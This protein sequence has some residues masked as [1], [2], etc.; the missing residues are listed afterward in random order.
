MPIVSKTL[1]IVA[2]REDLGPGIKRWRVDARDARGRNYVHG[3]LFGTQ[4]EAELVQTTVSWD[5]TKVDKANLL[6]WVQSR[7]TVASFD[8]SNRDIDEDAGEDHIYKWFAEAQG[9]DA[10]TVAWWMDSL[11]TGAFNKIRDR[12]G[13]TGEQGADIT[14]RFTFM[15]SVEPWYELT[16]EAS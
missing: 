11:N 8:Y 5:L 15:V 14:S 10:I 3:P 7:N 9:G 13:Y 1:T 2:N 16:V 6:S 4:A 12:L